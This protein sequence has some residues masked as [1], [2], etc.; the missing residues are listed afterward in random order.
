MELSVAVPI[1]VFIVASV[2]FS[3]IGAFIAKIDMNDTADGTRMASVIFISLLLAVLVTLPVIMW[4][5]P[6]E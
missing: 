2:L 4:C 1:I 5:M 3:V 6:I